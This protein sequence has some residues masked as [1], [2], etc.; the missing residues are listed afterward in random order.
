MW[1]EGG[2]AG[3]EGEGRSTDRIG[4]DIVEKRRRDHRRGETR[5]GKELKQR[6][7]KVT[8]SREEKP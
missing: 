6:M 1:E 8:E 3:T 5:K 4:E 2:E 7:A